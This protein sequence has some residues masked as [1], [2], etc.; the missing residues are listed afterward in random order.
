MAA[1]DNPL[2]AEE[3]FSLFAGTGGLTAPSHRGWHDNKA[4]VPPS[5][6]FGTNETNPHRGETKRTSDS[7]T[8]SKARAL[9]RRNDHLEA[10]LASL[11]TRSALEVSQSAKTKANALRHLKAVEEHVGLLVNESSA[12]LET[13]AAEREK[14]NALDFDERETNDSDVMRRLGRTNGEARETSTR[15]RGDT[16]NKHSSAAIAETERLRDELA[17]FSQREAEMDLEAEE[18]ESE[19]AQ[20]VM[21][22]ELLEQALRLAGGGEFGGGR[23]R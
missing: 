7:G 4:L 10:E 13:L 6:L 19:L 20:A 5:P 9:A 16:G 21:R 12:K 11:R 8:S 1:V 3:D 17:R 18:R 14:E 22:I 15:H 2:F 23:E